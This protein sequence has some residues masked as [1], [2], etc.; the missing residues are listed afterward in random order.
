M[1]M[2]DSF[3]G[4]KLVI[5]KN[6]EGAEVH[7]LTFGAIVQKLLVPDKAGELGDVVLGFDTEDPYKVLT[8]AGILRLHQKIGMTR[9]MIH[10]GWE[11]PLLWGDRRPRGQ[12]HCGREIRPQWSAVQSERQRSAEFAARGQVW[13]EPQALDSEQQRSV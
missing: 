6:A 4:E 12:P 2:Q 5:L 11:E 8:S 7:I 10:A 13:L 9:A 1:T 3:G